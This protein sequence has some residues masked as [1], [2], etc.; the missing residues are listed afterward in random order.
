MK[1]KKMYN[2]LHGTNIYLYQRSDM[3][4]I[5]TDTYLLGKFYSLKD[6]DVLLDIGCNN[7]ALLL[8][9]LDK[10][11]INNKLIGVDI[12]R[13]AIELARENLDLN[14]VKYELYC[15]D[16]KKFEYEKVDCIV[17]NPPYFEYNKDT[18]VK[19]NE[20]LTIARF[21]KYFP[22]EEVCKSFRRLIKDSGHIYMVHR[23]SSLGRIIK[24]LAKNNLSINRMQLVYDEN[25]E[26][27]ISVLLDIVVSEKSITKIIKP[28]I[29]KR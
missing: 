4:R 1:N 16:I 6:N 17:C 12:Q 23:A 20:S 3:F 22:L 5:N 27:A 13:D 11:T 14:K 18:N 7:G 15:T 29:I 24:E 26:Y 19:D 8:Y 9:S 25:V 2:Y 21:E 28:Q 10:N